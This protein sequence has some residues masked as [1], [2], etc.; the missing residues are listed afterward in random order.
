MR[1]D[2]LGR[3]RVNETRHTKLMRLDT[4]SLK[5]KF[6][7]WTGGKMGDGDVYATRF[8]GDVYALSWLSGF[9]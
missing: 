1:L 8:H 9:L 5:G 7:C 6:A 4:L 2:T 3:G